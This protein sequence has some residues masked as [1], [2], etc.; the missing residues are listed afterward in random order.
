MHSRPLVLRESTRNTRRVRIAG[1]PSRAPESS[2]AM[3]GKKK[4]SGEEF[5]MVRLPLS[6]IKKYKAEEKANKKKK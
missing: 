3:A 6:A 4:K 1:V 2:E 5:R